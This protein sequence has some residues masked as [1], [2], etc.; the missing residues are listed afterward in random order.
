MHL[1]RLSEEAERYLMEGRWIQ[2]DHLHFFGYFR[3][4]LMEDI[5]WHGLTYGYDAD[6]FWARHCQ[7]CPFSERWSLCVRDHPGGHD[8]ATGKELAP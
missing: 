6:G 3:H 1:E 8:P 4:L 2:R 5:G 7:E